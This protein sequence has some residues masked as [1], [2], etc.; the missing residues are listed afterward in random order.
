MDVIAFHKAYNFDFII[1]MNILRQGDM[2]IT[3][4][5]NE[6]IFSFRIPPG[7]Q[8]IDFMPNHIKK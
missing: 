6:T 4:A 2:A 1:G 3:N 7:I 5:N 8:H